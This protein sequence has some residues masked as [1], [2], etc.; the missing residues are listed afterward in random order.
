M[1][2]MP[3]EDLT[4]KEAALEAVC[5]QSRLHTRIKSPHRCRLHDRLRRIGEKT[6]L[7]VFTKKS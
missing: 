7:R 2:K 3:E 4:E 6:K 1:Q 5:A